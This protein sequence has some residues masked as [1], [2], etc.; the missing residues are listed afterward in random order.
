MPDHPSTDEPLARAGPAMFQLARLIP[1]TVGQTVAEDSDE[2]LNLQQILI[3]DTIDAEH[4]AGGQP[5][6]GSIAQRLGVDPSTASRLVANAVRAGNA[7]R[8]ASQHDGRSTN[9]ELTPQGLKL[10]AS[11]HRFQQAA[12]DQLTHGWSTR[13]KYE[14]ARLLVK[15]ADQ[16]AP[17]PQPPNRQQAVE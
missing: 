13:D 11:S 5:T 1:R 12:Y 9:L 6:V 10:L 15:L 8:I 7:R 3:V 2:A 4:S 16:P 17:R 14:L